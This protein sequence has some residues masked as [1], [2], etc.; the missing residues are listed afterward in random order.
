MIKLNIP[1]V[2]NGYIVDNVIWRSAQPDDAAWPL[3]AKA[4]CKSVLDLDNAVAA[5]ICKQAAL[6][7]KAGMNY[8]SVSWNG[9]STPSQA[10]IHEALTWVDVQACTSNTPS[11]VHC[12]HGSD[13][14][15]VFCACWR[16]HHDNWSVESA[17]DEALAALGLHGM[18]EIWMTMAVEQYARGLRC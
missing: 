6:I 8:K 11:I 9:V 10:E 3:L 18:H 14:T 5:T 12:L 17:I 7:N 1:G 13:R 15:G 16:I 4:G 2:R